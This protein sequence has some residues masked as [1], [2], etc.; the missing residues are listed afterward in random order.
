MIARMA[1]NVHAIDKWKRGLGVFGP[2]RRAF[3][4]AVLEA[5]DSYLGLID[6]ARNRVSDSLLL[7]FHPR[8]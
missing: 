4:D 6:Y 7:E 2:T 1:T 8:V 5:Y 3:V